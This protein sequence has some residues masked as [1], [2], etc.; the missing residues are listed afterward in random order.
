M[1]FDVEII[2]KVGIRYLSA[3]LLSVLLTDG[4][5]RTNLKKDIPVMA[6]T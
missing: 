4:L 5:D 2:Y 1:E 6:I 3:D